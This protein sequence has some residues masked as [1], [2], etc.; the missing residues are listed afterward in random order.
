MSPGSRTLARVGWALTV[1][2]LANCAFWL[3]TL[4]L[5]VNDATATW[6]WVLGVILIVLWLAYL[7]VWFRRTKRCSWRLLPI[8][9]I[10]VLALALAVTDTPRRWQW[11]YDQPRL[12]TAAQQVL[13]DPRTDF[14]DHGDRRIGTLRIHRTSK[15]AGVVAFAIPPT[16]NTTGISHLEYRPD[17]SEPPS[18]SV[19]VVK[20]L[21]SDWWHVI[22][23]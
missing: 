8:P 2:V 7:A 3:R 5:G 6:P 21:G 4:M 12:T 1:L 22:G 11:A 13:A 14:T 15:R 16:D 9:L 20:G 10:G 18:G 19:F 23:F 17:G